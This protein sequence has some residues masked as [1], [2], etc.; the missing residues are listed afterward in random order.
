MKIAYICDKYY[1]DK[2]VP[3][4]RFHAIDALGKIADVLCTGNGFHSWVPDLTVRENLAIGYFAADWIIVYKPENYDWSDNHIPVAT[5]F[6]DAWHTEQ[7]LSE[8]ETPNC[9]LV[10]MHHKNEMADWELRCPDVR[11]VNIPYPINPNVFKDYG[12]DKPIDVLLTGAIDRKIYPLRFRFERMIRTGA[13]HPYDAVHEKH[14]GYR[15]N[16]PNK[17]AVR[18][19]KLLG[20]AKVCLADTSKYGYAAEKYHEIPACGSVL[21]GNVPRE[22]QGDFRSFM[23][24]VNEAWPD[25]KIVQH[26]KRYLA[27]PHEIVSRSSYGYGYV[28]SN[29]TVDHYAR[30]LLNVLESSL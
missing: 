25:A 20:S 5:T 14:P 28:H 8:I 29:F 3:R 13:F 21:C 18:Y 10:I 22:R 1:W 11:F 19:A 30:E 2:K 4:T 12:Q 26:I 23:I 27:Q 7:R 6:N 9:R 15:L 24:E 17:E 16:D